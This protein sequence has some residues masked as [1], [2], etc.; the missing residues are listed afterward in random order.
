MNVQGAVLALS[1]LV[2]L[3]SASAQVSQA[4]FKS[5]KTA[6]DTVYR[7]LKL[8]PVNC[9]ALAGHTVICGDAPQSLEAVMSYLDKNPVIY[10]GPRWYGDENGSW[11]NF[12]FVK[13]DMYLTFDALLISKSKTVTRVVFTIENPPQPAPTPR[14]P[15]A[16][17]RLKQEYGVDLLPLGKGRYGAV[18]TKNNQIVGVILDEKAGKLCRITVPVPARQLLGWGQTRGMDGHLQVT[19]SQ[20]GQGVN[21]IFDLGTQGVCPRVG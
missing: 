19:T 6:A 1:M 21:W 7:G 5:M 17:A 20:M 18:A 12:A 4:E 8:K 3:S 14:E 10:M 11:K 13:A 2:S 16:R 15:S 9:P